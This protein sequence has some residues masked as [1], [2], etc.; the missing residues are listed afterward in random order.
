LNEVDMKTRVT[1]VTYGLSA[2][3]TMF[4]LINVVVLIG[5]AHKLAAIAEKMVKPKDEDDEKFS[6][7]YIGGG[8]MA[9]VELSLLEAKK[10]ISN[11]GKVI[12][13]MMKHLD[14][15]LLETDASVIRKKIKKIHK[16][17]DIADQLELEV[18]QYLIKLSETELSEKSSITIRSMLSAINDLERA[19]DVMYQMS[20][21]IERKIEAKVWF[22]PE[23]REHLIELFLKV[24]E[25]IVIM[26]DNLDGSYSNVEK[27]DARKVEDEIN[28]LRS[29]FRKQ[30]LK[31]IEN[32]DYNIKAGLIFVDLIS[33]A[34]KLG[35]HIYD[36]NSDVRGDSV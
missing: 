31:S 13:K 5:F 16:Y 24:N 9:S 18:G 14:L 27:D 11:F 21:V 15:L 7:E 12:A 33:S 4:N 28:Y 17:E 6:L 20:K 2:F 23:Q 32:G 19:A 10:E 29:K 3:H 34:E 35:D 1:A 26:Q 25:A 22:T 30:H 36:V 8:V